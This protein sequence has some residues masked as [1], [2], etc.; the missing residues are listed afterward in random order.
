MEISDASDDC[1][2]S[3]R[4][5]SLRFFFRD[6]LH[7]PPPRIVFFSFHFPLSPSSATI[8]CYRDG[9]FIRRPPSSIHPF[10]FQR[11]FIGKVITGQEKIARAAT[12]QGLAYLYIYIYIYRVPVINRVHIS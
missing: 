3:C 12:F 11:G 7:P 9:C 4:Q 6:H 5:F 1:Y 8:P 10:L 2:I